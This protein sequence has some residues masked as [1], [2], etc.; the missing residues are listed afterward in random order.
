M[1]A[2]L[3]LLHAGKSIQQVRRRERHWATAR[4]VVAGSSI[5]IA[6]AALF[7]T[8]WIRSPEVS[9]HLPV[10]LAVDDARFWRRPWL[11]QFDFSPDGER[12]VFSR[13]G[14]VSTWEAKTRI[15]RRLELVG[16]G[17]WKPAGGGTTALARWAPDSRRFVFQAQK[18]VG[19]TVDEPIRVY[20]FFVVNAD[21]GEVRQIGSDLPE[22]ERANDLCWRPDGQAITYVVSI[23][24]LMTLSLSG[25]RTV[26]KDSNHPG[27]APRLA[28]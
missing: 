3:E 12:I 5:A 13:V 16:I 2:D 27:N 28:G 1:H 8:T 26:W 23:R 19:G 17:D 20:A 14:A 25:E 22:A 18:Q 4:K 15:T 10:R 9:R 6:L 21:T 7:F 11:R 24:S